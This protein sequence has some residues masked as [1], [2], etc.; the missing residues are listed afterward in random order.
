MAE[1]NTD[2]IHRSGDT[3]SF[4]ER[5][6]DELELGRRA[7][8]NKIGGLMFATG[9]AGAGLGGLD[10]FVRDNSQSK[11]A[12]QAQKLSPRPEEE[13]RKWAEAKLNRFKSGFED[14]ADSS[15]VRRI[16]NYLQEAGP[17]V[18]QAST[19]LDR[20]VQH[21]ITLK[22][23]EEGSDKT[24]VEVDSTLMALGGILAVGSFIIGE[25]YTDRP[26]VIQRLIIKLHPKLRGK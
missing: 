23:L 1:R 6:N 15:E 12:D 13:D 4:G 11:L 5:N 18:E 16:P 7:F 19:I 26:N 25:D 20:E 17:V 22:R 24:R 14:L 3:H 21:N 2:R 9:F 8:L 10:A